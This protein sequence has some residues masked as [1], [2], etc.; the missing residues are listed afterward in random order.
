MKKIL[1]LFCLAAGLFQFLIVPVFGADDLTLQ[2][3]VVGDSE[4]QEHFAAVSITAGPNYTVQS[5]AQVTLRAGQT[6]IL[7]PGV[8]IEKGAKFAIRIFGEDTTGPEVISGY[9]QNGSVV[10]ALS[11]SLSML[12]TFGDSGSGVK[13]VT[14]LNGD[15]EDITSQA[16]LTANTIEF[17]LENP[18]DG[19]YEFILVIEDNLG[20]ITSTPI[21]FTVDSTIPVTEVSMAGGSY[22]DP[23]SIDLTT[24]EP[25]TIYYSTDGYP[26]FVGAD[27]TFSATAPITGMTIE[28]VFNLQFF[29]VDPAGNVE[30]TQSEV[31]VI[32]E[33]PGLTISPAAVYNAGQNRVELTWTSLPDFITGHHV[34]RCSSQTDKTIMEQSL[35]GGYP[36]PNRFRLT[37]APLSADLYYDT[38]IVPGATYWYGVTVI[39]NN[40]EGVISPL[41]VVDIEVDTAAANTADAIARA[42]VWLEK[43]QHFLGY[44]GEKSSTRILTTSQVLNAFNRADMDNAAIRKAL[45][46]LRGEHADNN[47]F[48]SRQIM[49]LNGYGQNVDQQVNRLIA[50]AFI[51][52][53]GIYGWGTQK[54]FLIDAIDTALGCNAV[55]CASVGLKDASG[56]ALYNMAWLRLENDDTL[57]STE[58]GRFGWVPGQAG[59]VYPSAYVY[60]TIDNFDSNA[61]DVEWIKETQVANG[62]GAF[63]NGLIDTAAVLLWLELT[64]IEKTDVVDYLVSQQNINGSWNDDAYVTGLCLEALLK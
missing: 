39:N 32:G 59:A 51:Y 42:T 12:I 41:M 48:L 46:Y 11:G 26:P 56:S 17:I 63:G 25:A 20:N 1:S 45:F 50:Q 28:Q 3:Q 2:D 34:Y 37:Q 18:T 29:A 35:A 44:W 13:T 4:V 54:R 30:D 22:D 27:N 43:T 61:F 36:P 40:I 7:K 55:S 14:L 6:V 60:W 21:S 19:D 5:G 53:T 57:Q 62:N 64:D 38:A 23:I 16:T 31:Y 49:T 24:S 33:V 15:D 9:P 47:D 58:S 8:A 52:G 10:S